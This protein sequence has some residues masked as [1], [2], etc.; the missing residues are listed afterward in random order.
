MAVDAKTRLPQGVRYVSLVSYD[1]HMNNDMH[2][3]CTHPTFTITEDMAVAL[4]RAQLAHLSNAALLDPH[5]DDDYD[6]TESALD[7]AHALVMMIQLD[8][9]ATDLPNLLCEINNYACDGVCDELCDFVYYS[10][11][12]APDDCDE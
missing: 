1:R 12:F 11:G 7:L 3:N 6:Y 9:Y 4:M 10:T 2:T 5:S 8:T